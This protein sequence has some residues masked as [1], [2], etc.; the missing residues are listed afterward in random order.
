MYLTNFFLVFLPIPLVYSYGLSYQLLPY[1]LRRQFGRFSVGLG[2]LVVLTWCLNDVLSGILFGITIPAMTDQP[3]TGPAELW[4]NWAV[5]NPT[6]TNGTLF[7]VNLVA[8]LLVGTRLYRQ[9]FQKQRESQRLEN[10]KLQTELQLLKLQLNPAF[11]F[12]LLERLHQ[13]TQQQPAQASE[14]VLTLAHFLRYSLYESQ[15]PRVPLAWEIEVIEQYVF[16][17]QTLHPA[18]MEVSL[19]IRGDTGQHRIPPL[20]LFPIV[21]QAFGPFSTELIKPITGDPFWVTI[22][23]A[24]SETHLTLKTVHGQAS[25]QPDAFNWLESLKKQLNFYYQENF[26]LEL[27][28]K[29]D[30]YVVSLKL[31]LSITHHKEPP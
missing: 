18:G 11:L 4:A 5:F 27:L 22:D 25:S 1:V 29:P 14:L 24:V 23:L 3:V 13:T 6:F 2:L 8:G 15:R 20:I 9:W 30:A 31:L 12:G 19:A 10:Q 17:Q 7:E 16:L 28:S 26:E 21:E